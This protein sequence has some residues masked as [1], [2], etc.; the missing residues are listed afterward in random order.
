MAVERRGEMSGDA[1]TI[2]CARCGKSLQ[3]VSAPVRHSSSM[4]TNQFFPYHIGE[5]GL[6]CP[7]SEK[8]VS[9]DQTISDVYGSHVKEAEWRPEGRK[10]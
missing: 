8:L 10:V 9:D 4:K 2:K 5:D 6:P 3:A 7:N 1:V